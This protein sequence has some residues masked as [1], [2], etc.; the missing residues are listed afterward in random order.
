[1]R[2][3]VCAIA[4][5]HKQTHKLPWCPMLLLCPDKCNN[6]RID[7]TDQAA[8]SVGVSCWLLWC[9]RWSTRVNYREAWII[10]ARCGRFGRGMDES[11]SSGF[12]GSCNPTLQDSRRI[13]NCKMRHWEYVIRI[14][15]VFGTRLKFR[16]HLNWNERTSTW[17]PSEKSHAHRQLTRLHVES[18]E[19]KYDHINS[20]QWTTFTLH[21]LHSRAIIA[22][23]KGART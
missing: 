13:C 20:C 19:S 2:L 9:G 4:G 23:Q 5:I 17:E 6:L 15:L 7:V 22:P 10:I 12:V 16:T 21:N 11:A 14:L 18:Y 1:M 3:C 8:G